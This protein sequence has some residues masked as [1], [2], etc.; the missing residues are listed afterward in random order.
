MPNVL[1]L[2]L[3]PRSE[4]NKVKDCPIYEQL[5]TIFMDSSADGKYAQSSHYEELGKSGGRDNADLTTCPESI[6][7]C[8]GN[9]SAQVN[10]SSTEK[11]A[12]VMSDRKKK[13]TSDIQSWGQS[14]NDQEILDTMAK[15]MLEMVAA[16]KVRTVT[17]VPKDDKFTIAYCIRA[18]DDIEGIDERLYFAALDLF[19]DPNLREIFISL[20][21]DKIRL[22]WLQGKCSKTICI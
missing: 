4:T 2:Q 9:L 1:L 11:V 12:K 18:L 13:R 6:V 17:A 22:T 15:A 10:A 5:C 16:S 19:E 3:Q 20:K 21:S 14:R 8:S 7:L